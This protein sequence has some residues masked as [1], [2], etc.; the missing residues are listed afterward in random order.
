MNAFNFNSPTLIQP[1]KKLFLG[2]KNLRNFYSLG[3]HVFWSVNWNPWLHVHTASSS[4][5]LQISSHPPL[6]ALSHGCTG[7]KRQGRRSKLLVF[8]IMI[9]MLK[10]TNVYQQVIL[11]NNVFVWEHA[12]RFYLTIVMVLEFNNIYNF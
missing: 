9:N 7:S 8:M 11:S 10:F 3:S 12:T 2:V 5:L 1:S 4:T 6:S